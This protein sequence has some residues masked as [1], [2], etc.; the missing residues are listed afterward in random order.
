[1]ALSRVHVRSL[2]N[3][4]RIRT[5][6]TRYFPDVSPAADRRENTTAAYYSLYFIR[7]RLFANDRSVPKFNVST[8]D[9]YFARRRHSFPS[10]VNRPPETER[11]NG[12]KT[13]VRRERI[14]G[15]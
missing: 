12:M 6:T 14:N 8:D 13:A 1:V 3:D 10:P 15:I 11:P 9:Y 5:K 2:P 4:Q 7:R